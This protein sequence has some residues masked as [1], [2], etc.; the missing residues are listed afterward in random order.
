[1][2]I[3][4]P[5]TLIALL[6]AVHYG[7]REERLAENAQRISEQ[8]RV[9]H[10]RVATVMECWG[11]VGAALAKAT[12]SFNKAAA[13]VEQR[14][15]PGARTLAELGAAGKKVVPSI[16]PIDTRPRV[17]SVDPVPPGRESDG[18]RLVEAS[19]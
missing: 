5:T 7:W 14:L 16:E 6:Q 4:T 13:S 8:G 2:L 12:E 18:P 15:L 19:G 1:V 11:R 3:A 10:E 9:L 17:V